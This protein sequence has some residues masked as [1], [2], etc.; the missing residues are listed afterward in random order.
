MEANLHLMVS[1]LS[2]FNILYP[3]M[4]CKHFFDQN[5]MNFINLLKIIFSKFA[6]SWALKDEKDFNRQESWPCSLEREL[7]IGVE[8]LGELTPYLKEP[9]R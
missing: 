1:I 5:Y 6:L 4:Q 2:V 9:F 7:K 3:N 8:K